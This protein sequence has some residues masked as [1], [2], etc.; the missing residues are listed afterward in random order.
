MTTVWTRPR[1][2]VCAAAAAT[3]VA[4]ALLPATAGPAAA[5]GSGLNS[6]T[7]GAQA[8]RLAVPGIET[9]AP[10]ATRSASGPRL[11]V[12]PT[13]LATTS[14]E[15]ALQGDSPYLRV[16]G[17]ANGDWP[18]TVRVRVYDASLGRGTTVTDSTSGDL[19]DGTLT[20][21]WGRVGAHLAAGN[22]FVVWARRADG[23]WAQVGRFGVRGSL[24]AAGPAT[25][26]GGMTTSIA[27][28][29][30]TWSWQSQTL[31]GPASDVGVS[32]QWQ[33]RQPAVTGLS[34]GWRMPVSSGSPWA[35]LDE[36]ALRASALVGPA[37]PIAVRTGPRT[38][39]V[40]FAYSLLGR[41]TPRGFALQQRVGS[42]WRP[43]GIA[44]ALRP[45][46]VSVRLLAGATALRVVLIDK[47]ATEY[48]RAAALRS[49]RARPL[50]A[51]ATPDQDECGASTNS[52]TGPEAV[53]LHGWNGLAL[54]FLRN[55]FGVY[56][57]TYGGDRIP[58]YANT[59]A[60][61]DTAQGRDWLFT[62]AAGVQ[63]RFHAG[64]V[65]SVVNQ[66][67][68]VSTLAWSGARLVRLTN[69][70]GR[71]MTFTYAG[72]GDCPSARWTAYSAPPDGLL[73]RITYP[74]GM[75]TDLG[76]VDGGA[77]GAELGLVKDPGNTGTGLG[78]DSVGRLTATRSALT[79]RAATV[80][81]ALAAAIA[82]TTYDDLG[83]V[84]SLTEAPAAP[85]AASMT[86]TIDYPVIG[87]IALHSSDPVVAT[88][89]G[90]APGSAMSNEVTL[91]PG[92]FDQH[93]ARDATGATTASGQDG[94]TTTSTDARGLVTTSTYDAVGNVVAQ[95]GPALEGAQ[96]Q[97]AS[98]SATYDTTRVGHEDQRYDGFRASIY[99]A[100]GFTGTVTPDFWPSSSSN[101][102]EASW[103]VSTAS[104]SAVASAI[105]T[106]TKAEDDAAAGAWT[107]QV[108]TSPGVSA[109][110][111]V[112]GTACETEQCQ[113]RG[114]AAG[115]KQI[116][117]ELDRG[118]AS[119]W[120][121]LTVAPGA[122]QPVT[123]PTTQV[124]PGFDNLTAVTSNDITAAQPDPATRYVY[125]APETGKATGVVFP[126][127][128]TSALSYEQVNPGKGTWGRL[129]T[130]TTAGGH[131]QTTTYWP[132]NAAVA[133]PEVCGGEA[134]VSGQPKTITRQDG[135]AVTSY[136]DLAG[137][138]VAGVTTGRGGASETVCT[139]YADDGTPVNSSQYD[140]T[141][142]L[143][144]RVDTLVGV[145]GDPLTTAQTITHGL[146]AAVDPGAVVTTRTT[147]DLRGSA[148][149][150][151][152]ATGTVTSTTYTAL[153]TPA[154]VTVTPPGDATPLLRFAYTYRALDGA[155]LAVTVNDA[156]AVS[157]AYVAGKASVEGVTYAGGAANISLQY[158][159]SG[160]PDVLV[161]LAGTSRYAQSLALSDFGRILSQDLVATAPGMRTTDSR[162][163]TYDA[164][165]R[166]TRAV[167]ASATTGSP[168]T[169]TT[170]GYAYDATQS[171]TCGAAGTAYP[172]ASADVLR[173]GGTRAGV[174]FLS[175][176]DA[177]GRLV[178][179]TDPLVTGDASA[180]TSATLTHDALGRVTSVTGVARPLA[181]TWAQGTTLAQVAEGSGADAVRTTFDTFGGRALRTTVTT[182][183]STST[184]LYAYSSLTSSAPVLT[185]SDAN[186]IT[187]VSYPLPGGARVDAA[188]GATPVLELTGLDG[189]T[190]AR[191]PVPSLAVD[192][193]S[194]PTVSETGLT[195]RFGPY[196]EPLVTPTVDIASP[197]PL[198]GWQSGQRQQTL[199]GTSS[200]TLMGARPYLPALGEFLAPDPSSDS[201]PNQYGFT[202]GDPVN[203]ADPNGQANEWSWFW[204]VVAGITLVAAIALDIAT[205]GMAAPA[206]GAGFLAWAGYATMTVGVPLVA[207]YAYGK[208][209]QLSVYTQTEPSEG[210]DGMR[211]AM[212]WLTFAETLRSCGGMVVSA[213]MRG[214]AKVQ[215]WW[216]TRA[217]A[218]HRALV[219]DLSAA[220]ALAGPRRSIALTQ[221]ERL[222]FGALDL[223]GRSALERTAGRLSVGHAG[224]T[225]STVR[226]GFD[227]KNF[228]YLTDFMA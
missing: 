160:R 29:E 179:T 102:L 67:Q 148:V 2:A 36:S 14:G 83:R 165:G 59:L 218:A 209:E 56:E 82:T 81:P 21:G 188:A 20:D 104:M 114:L 7:I 145:D 207:W 183:G 224:I 112:A 205:A 199:P 62:D 141:G 50:R 227:R 216:R 109:R 163:Y 31:P 88:V 215:T 25:Q 201:A 3:F 76:Y 126:G 46:T 185:L 177:N 110:V 42:R 190:L 226:L 80:T 96:T 206:T 155:P 77:A 35:T 19:W 129:L 143:V 192:G 11:P 33:A 92:T 186:A 187:G 180:A 222:G 93:T 18:P 57:Q 196:G 212:A 142:A 146:A 86:Q 156:P 164:E 52:V 113:V 217:D 8:I 147:Y 16:S 107:F 189:A 72:S 138:L 221:T 139:R 84:A 178:S 75:S 106:P 58:G 69:G 71:A 167:L 90:T 13:A 203:G 161:A 181:L 182:S 200:I 108:A 195:P 144:E 223:G 133:L 122:G 158:A 24:D 32:L 132:D 176:H 184:A 191:I 23:S 120:F 194:G 174:A 39:R 131:T 119:G 95:Q 91:D 54:T 135:N 1:T 137:R 74:S 78:W 68:P 152:D 153:G 61:C 208:A 99:P 100:A 87:E 66:G 162:G 10:I 5:S 219:E 17:L 214:A 170:Y 44:G 64:H 118:A 9:V 101:G 15:N 128:L 169:L 43:V 172:H 211:S 225:D 130:Y 210:L 149:R 136:Y 28:G 159:D 40:S 53:V 70:V 140:V 47:T 26:A 60:I 97:G 22:G 34:A 85:G 125:A 228:F 197:R 117:V 30:L 6:G 124:A 27:T 154:T 204:Q 41:V 48:S 105:W 173:T 111:I 98:V 193:V 166:L 63:T 175:C 94:R 202:A 103:H 4:A 89:H 116:S 220:A 123:V 157:V 115:P 198:Y 45:G 38:A 171:S 134:E 127:G 51:T 73:C 12:L 151:V 168:T 65:V 79:L 37:A 121:R 49:V 150:Y 55:D 213:G